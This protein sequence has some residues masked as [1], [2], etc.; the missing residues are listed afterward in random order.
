MIKLLYNIDWKVE[1]SEGNEQYI[2][3]TNQEN[4]AEKFKSTDK[5]LNPK[6]DEQCKHEAGYDAE[7]FKDILYTQQNEFK[8][9]MVDVKSFGGLEPRQTEDQLDF[10]A[11]V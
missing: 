8:T 11:K 4:I 6:Q 9:I 1:L 10:L 3:E 7:Q 5:N 2:E